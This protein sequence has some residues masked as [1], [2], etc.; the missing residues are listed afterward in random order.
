MLLRVS[1]G[2]TLIELIA[3]IIVLGVVSLGIT[4]FLSTSTQI[5]VDVSERDRILSSSRFVIERLNRELRYAL[6][7]S[8]RVGVHIT[9]QVNAHCL[10]FVPI[11]WSS[12]YVDI[13]VSPESASSTFDS[14]ELT[15]ISGSYDDSD[16]VNDYVFVYPTK[17]QDVYEAAATDGT[18]RRAALSSV[19]S[20]SDEVTVTLQS[21][22][23]FEED[24]PVSRFYI[25]DEPVSY[26]IEASSNRITRHSDYGFHA[27]QNSQVGGSVLGDGVLMAENAVNEL[28][29]DPEN[30]LVN[31]DDPFRVAN[32]SLTR[33]AVVNVMLRF[34]LN[35]ETVVFNNEVHLHNVP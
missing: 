29:S 19:G 9:S 1:K 2:F 31:E 16:V 28:S 5:Y 6:P 20:G 17:N 15:G 4:N 10:E 11:K 13:P 8:A 27:V 34:K 32:A 22:M 18:T 14:A 25:V 30:D 24:S 7:N 33:N 23:L 21:A 12:F 3:V 35:D 26:C